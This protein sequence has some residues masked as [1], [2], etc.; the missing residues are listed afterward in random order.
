M[1]NS[2][3]AKR[4]NPPSSTGMGSKFIM[5]SEMLI[6]PKREN[7]LIIPILKPSLKLSF[8]VVPSKSVILAGPETALSISTP[9]KSV[10][11]LF[12]VNLI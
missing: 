9:L 3:N 7:K 1:I 4:I 11:I 2:I 6:M 12:I 10:P 8:T 5:K